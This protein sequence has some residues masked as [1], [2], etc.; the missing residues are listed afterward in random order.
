LFLLFKIGPGRAMLELHVL[1][2]RHAAGRN[3]GVQLKRQPAH[4]RLGIAGML[5]LPVF[6][7]GFEAALPDVAPRADK[8]EYD[9]YAQRLAHVYPPMR[10]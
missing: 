9:I 3:V 10:D 1:A 2:P 5:R 7:R 6:E 8:V 4:H